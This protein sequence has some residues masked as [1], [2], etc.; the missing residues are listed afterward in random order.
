MADKSEGPDLKTL[1]DKGLG[2]L[3]ITDVA[4]LSG[5]ALVELAGEALMSVQ[6][7]FHQKHMGNLMYQQMHL[8]MVNTALST[9]A[10]DSPAALIQGELK[11]NFAKYKSRFL[12]NHDRVQEA[13]YRKLFVDCYQDFELYIADVS[14]V[15]FLAF[16]QLLVPADDIA[17][18]VTVGH[19]DLFGVRNI[20]ELRAAVVERRVKAMLQADNIADVLR[21]V[22]R[23]FGIKFGLEKKQVDE[24]VMTSLKRNLFVHNDGVVN[25]VFRALVR[26]HGLKM[27]GG[28]SV[29]VR[30]SIGDKEFEA[31]QQLVQKLATEVLKSGLRQLEQIAA[32][33]AARLR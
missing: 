3:L 22:E 29:G 31:A 17:P 16:P 13:T 1:A 32:Y 33:Q 5:A 12:E 8:V 25:E 21:K 23:T 11:D 28:L 30:M 26:K 20:V 9:F 2:K 19:S 24:L 18:T 27:P 10:L 15:L 14:S 7:K 4:G 6:E